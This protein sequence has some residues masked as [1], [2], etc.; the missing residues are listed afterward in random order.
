[1]EYYGS[2]PCYTQHN[3]VYLNDMIINSDTQSEYFPNTLLELEIMQGM[4]TNLK[5]QNHNAQ[6]YSCALIY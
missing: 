2:P 3:N 1:M 5:L 4:I 6:L